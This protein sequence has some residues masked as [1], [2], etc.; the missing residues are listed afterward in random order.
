M[1][2]SG[3]DQRHEGRRCCHRHHQVRGRGVGRRQPWR[4]SR[5]EWRLSRGCLIF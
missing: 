3:L 1:I 5:K 4:T 2:I